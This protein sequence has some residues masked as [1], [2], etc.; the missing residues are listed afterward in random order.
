MWRICGGAAENADGKTAFD[1]MRAGD[2][3]ATAVVKNY[4]SYLAEGVTDICNIF[5]PDAVVLSGG[6]CA[7]GDALLKPLKRKVA[8]SVF[9]G[10]KYAP[11]KILTAQLGNDAG[12]FGAARLAMDALPV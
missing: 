12:I 5:R 6:I 2:K 4:I 9:G 10:M 8:N 1:G 7:E 11:V 3:A